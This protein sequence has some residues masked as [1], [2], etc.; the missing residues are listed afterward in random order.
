MRG[1]AP[2]SITAAPV[3]TAVNR[4]GAVLVW[5]VMIVPLMMLILIGLT[6]YAAMALARVELKNSTDAAALSAIKSW[7]DLNRDAAIQDG[8]I[9][10]FANPVITRTS[11]TTAASDL[12]SAD[13]SHRVEFV[14]GG[15]VDMDGMRTFHELPGLSDIEQVQALGMTPGLR[16]RRTVRVLGFAGNWLG[17]DFGPYVV[18]TESFARMCPEQNVPQLMFVDAADIATDSSQE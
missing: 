15:T 4:R 13:E 16:V 10:V 2:I 14:F 12:T 1:L 5:F 9:A 11:A 18:T 17:V 8:H 3:A 6:D 7:S